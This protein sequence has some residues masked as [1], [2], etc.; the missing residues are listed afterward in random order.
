MKIKILILALIVCLVL[1]FG[2]MV[3]AKNTKIERVVITPHSYFDLAEHGVDVRHGFG[4]KVSANVPVDKI[5]QFINRF[6]F[7]NIIIL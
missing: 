7:Y 3:S 6:V 5:R 2:S 1:V 4:K